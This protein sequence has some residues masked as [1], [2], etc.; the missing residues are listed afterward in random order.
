MAT[1]CLR[2]WWLVPFCSACLCC[3]Y[4]ASST[5]ATSSGTP[6]SSESPSTW[7]SSPYR[8][9]QTHTHTHTHTQRERERK[10]GSYQIK[11]EINF[12]DSSTM[13]VISTM[14][15]S[16]EHTSELQS[17]LNLVCR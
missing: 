17:H 12:M 11:L 4:S 3:C 2:R 1:G 14:F 15:R 7:S 13:N 16:E 9:T 10:C 8:Y 5:P 6:P